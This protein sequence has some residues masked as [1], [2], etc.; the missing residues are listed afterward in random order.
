VGIA[1]ALAAI[2]AHGLVDHSF[3]LVDLAYVFFLLLGLAVWLAHPA[4]DPIQAPASGVAPSEPPAP[5]P[6]Q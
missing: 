4:N 1:G 3:F 5:P 2:V 6:G